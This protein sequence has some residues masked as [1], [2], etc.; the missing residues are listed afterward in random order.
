VTPDVRAGDGEA[1][2]NGAVA[3]STQWKAPRSSVSHVIAFVAI[4]ALAGCMGEPDA[5]Y[6]EGNLEPTITGHCRVSGIGS[7]SSPD[8]LVG[9]VHDEGGVPAGSWMHVNSTHSLEGTPDF[10][11]CRIN[12][13]TRAFIDGV[14]TWGGVPGHRFSIEVQDRTRPDSA[15]RV[16]AAPTTEEIVASRIHAPTRWEDGTAEFTL[17]ADATIPAS[18]PVTEGNAHRGGHAWITF[19][20]Y[21]D[22][23]EVRCRYRS[24]SSG[25]AYVFTHCERRVECPPRSCD[26]DCWE[27]DSSLRA[28]GTIDIS[29][30][31]VHVQTASPR[32]PRTTVT[33]QLEVTPYEL[34]PAERDHYAINIF[35][36]S[37]GPAVYS[38]SGDLATGDI[39]V[40]LLP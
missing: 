27:T 3:V 20:T 34:P 25:S 14:G 39:S 11:E 15:S 16:A 6:G 30:A 40:V 5:G 10:L 23:D 38:V 2:T 8:A 21:A 32:Y 9:E 35:P 4:A 22:H 19:T 26:D 28:G 31:V 36:P 37:G 17:G 7:L 33:V 18:L 29:S 12:G 1:V 24:S 13:S